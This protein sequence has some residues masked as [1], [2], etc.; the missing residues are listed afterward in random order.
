MLES[1]FIEHNF[2]YM[3]YVINLLLHLYRKIILKEYHIHI[4]STLL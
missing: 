4:S 3:L 1:H 2:K